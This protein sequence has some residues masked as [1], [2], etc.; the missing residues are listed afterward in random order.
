MPPVAY[1]RVRA[2]KLYRAEARL[3][4]SR[5]A[6]LA[7]A[8]LSLAFFL[9]SAHAAP[10]PAPPSAAATLPALAGKIAPK[11]VAAQTPAQKN[12]L[13]PKRAPKR[14]STT[15]LHQPP[16][17]RSPAPKTAVNPNSP[18]F[19]AR[20]G[21]TTA[22]MTEG[23]TTAV[24]PNLGYEPVQLGIF[25]ENGMANQQ[26]VNIPLSAQDLVGGAP[27]LPRPEA[28]FPDPFGWNTWL[29]DRGIAIMLDNTDE[30]S[31][32]ITP[33]TKGL[34]LRQGS[35]DAGQYSLENDIDW[36]KLAGLTGF[37]THIVGVGRYGIPASRMFGDNIN[38]SSEIY[39]GGGNVFFHLV[40]AYGE[41]TLFG[42]RL[43]I[44]AGRMSMLSD[45]SSSPLYCTFMNNAFC[46]NLKTSTDNYARSSYPE[47][48]WAVRARG[49]P[50]NSTYLQIGVYFPETGIYTNSQQR[51]GFKFNGA[52]I[53]G[54]LT[55]IE[56]GWEPQFGKEHLQGHYKIGF[57]P[58]TSK[59]ILGLYNPMTTPQV[60]VNP[61]HPDPATT[62]PGARHLLHGGWGAWVL[63]DQMLLRHHTKDTMEGGLIAFAGAYWDKDNIA[64][65]GEL[66]DGGLIDTGFWPARPLDT[67]GVAFSYTGASNAT[68]KAQRWQI[69]HGALPG[70]GQPYPSP[71][72]LM[73][74][75][76]GVQRWGATF[77][78]TYRIHVVPGIYFA[79][80]FQY[81]FN[82]GMQRR[83]KD[84]AMLGFKSHVQLF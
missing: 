38:P 61:Y 15:A 6:R 65:R 23:I 74:G 44:A 42:G 37:E 4:S 53:S 57:A 81:Y 30:Y 20:S 52:D 45:F 51:T 82:P 48:N 25:D 47:A 22:L 7:V 31:G 68:R 59:H 75:S 21:A 66:F 79:P 27:A 55:P 70:P 41:E 84:A 77:E 63:V 13:A 12:K 35:S 29:R 10:A 76:Y 33:P 36:E 72:P 8:L 62:P 73:W 39:G 26:R 46:G 9:T 78:A 2:A 16:A 24:T 11:R 56:A 83:L 49:R 60:R 3:L 64:D 5:R 54:V 80:D 32:A 18:A 14:T 50:T 1:P 40:Y 19:K 17:T 71:G 43:N 34:G 58:D 69:A 28:I 67:V